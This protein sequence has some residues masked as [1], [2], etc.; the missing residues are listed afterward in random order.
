MRALLAP[1]LAAGM[2]V[3]C[4]RDALAEEAT[5]PPPEAPAAP[6]GAIVRTATPVALTL[7]GYVEAY[8]GWNFGRPS[9]GITAY[10]TFDSR[11][12][13]FT[14]SN[15]V[16]DAAWSRDRVSGRLA[17][18]LG[19]TGATYYASEPSR[20][21]GGG[22]TANDASLWRY[23]QQA[24]LG[25]RADVGRG[26]LV[27]MGLFLSPI[28]PEG[29]AIKDQ[30]TW[31]RS[32]LFSALPFYHTGLRATY[33]L[34]DAL[35]ATVAAY[36]GWNSVVDNNDE[37]SVSASMTYAVADAITVQG[38]YFGGVERDRG[39]AEG[40]AFRHL[41]D[42]YVTV[43][44]TKAL[45]FMA[46]ADAGFEAN[47]FGT[48]SWEGGAIYARLQALQWLYVVARGDRLHEHVAT[49]L[50][51]S[52]A[53]LFFPTADVA[54]ATLTLDARPQDGL[55]VRLEYRHDAA[56]APMYFRGA[57]AGDGVTSP[58]VPTSRTQDTLT[59]GATAWF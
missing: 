16:L 42:A 25:Y 12:D 57:V 33:P 52:A 35:S 47:H 32:I 22:V 18:Q 59:L 5:A 19:S 4:S 48:S 27:E 20:P 17:L 44:P 26:L 30:W 15:A 13:S 31:S 40:R 53:R 58:Y 39:V 49:S 38:L 41:F 11:H 54:S 37:K 29:I 24:N 10:R 36:D 21:G 28:G 3:A 34:T 9:N 14:L 1:V 51:G 6:P 55:S 7:A 43:Y 50:G 2:V 23:V 8:F 56:G 46:H 45:A